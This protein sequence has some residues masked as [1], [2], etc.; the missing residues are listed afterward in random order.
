[1]PPPRP[2]NLGLAA[3]ALAAATVAAGLVLL[4][5]PTLAVGLAASSL[6]LLGRLLAARHLDG[7][8]VE[9]DLPRR[10]RAHESFPMEIRVRP[11]PR[12]PT[13]ATVRLTDPLAP[14]MRERSLDLPA[15]GGRT[16]RCTGLPH[17]RG[18]LPPRPWLLA[19]TW[20]LGLFLTE[21][22]GAFR[23]DHATLVL[24]QPWLP[25]RLLERL[26]SLSSAS[27]ERPLEAADP[28]AEF[29]LLRE[30][31]PGDP[32]RGIRWPASLRSGRLLFAETEPPRPK[33]PGYGIIL[34]SYERPG[35][36]V[37]P[38]AYEQILRIAAGLLLRFQREEIPTVFCQAPGKALRLASRTAFAKRLDALALS[39]RFPLSSL[40]R[41]FAPPCSRDDDPFR[42]C[43]EV[44]VLGDGP[45]A[46]WEDAA[47]ARFPRCTCLDTTALT[48]A[49]R[50][51]LL[52][53]TKPSPL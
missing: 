23:D 32:V 1:M 16:L 19:S 7:F 12:F 43:D 21:R 17:R 8:S 24:P 20:P 33:P 38:E 22:Q 53:R 14:A 52:A 6:I 49:S 13:D 42:S 51:A 41:I 36:V 40:D 48:T 9:R 2:T 15:P 18:P 10:A 46:H 37:V 4:S 31:R 45:L 44:F 28:L 29:R 5:G 47:R 30:F 3:S 27:A 25:P 39:L 26:E 11:G 34:H 50:P 35:S